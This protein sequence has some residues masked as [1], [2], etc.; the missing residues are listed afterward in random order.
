MRLELREKIGFKGTPWLSRGEL[1]DPNA[2]ATTDR[3]AQEAD[4]RD[5]DSAAA[6]DQVGPLTALEVE[7]FVPDMASFKRG[8]T[9]RLGWAMS[10]GS[11]P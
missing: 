10:H 8:R 5:R 3:A 6:A 7:A 1:F 4:H 11:S 2:G 9:W